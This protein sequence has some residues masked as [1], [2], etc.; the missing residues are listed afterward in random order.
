MKLKLRMKIVI[1]YKKFGMIFQIAPQNSTS[2][3]AHRF[4][5]HSYCIN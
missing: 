5:S 1:A 3:F 4:N 2:V